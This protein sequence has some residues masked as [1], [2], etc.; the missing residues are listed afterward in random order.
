MDIIQILGNL[1]FD[2]RIALANLVNFLII[3]LI[4]KKFAFKPIAQALK[5]REDKIKQG[6]EDAQKS[7]AELQMAKQ[8]YEK[9]LLAARSEANRIIASA[10]R[11]TDRMQASCKWQSEEEAKRIIERTDKIIQNEKQKMM[12][13]LKK[14]VV[15]LVIDATEK[16]T[17]QNISKEKHEALIK[18]MLSK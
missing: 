9:S 11:E 8:S 15:I 10:Q 1:G 12:Q 17:K 5:K 2:W 6:V 3:L 14:E 16:L 18:E 13:D 4:L 7:S